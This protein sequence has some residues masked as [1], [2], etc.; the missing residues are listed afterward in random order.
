ML[1]PYLFF[2]VKMSTEM[3][4]AL[5][6][7]IVGAFYI[8]ERLIHLAVMLFRWYYGGETEKY[9]VERNDSFT[10]ELGEEI[11]GSNCYITCLL[12]RREIWTSCEHLAA[13]RACENLPAK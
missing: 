3:I 6:L 9:D 4:V 5:T 1:S 13:K 8:E 2:R 10:P 7:I 11:Q 12:Y